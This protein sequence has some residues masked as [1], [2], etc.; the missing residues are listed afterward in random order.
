MEGSMAP[1]NNVSGLSRRK[2]GFDSPWGYHPRLRAS[3]YFPVGSQ[4]S[5]ISFL[6]ENGP[7][8]GSQTVA[9]LNWETNTLGL[10]R[11]SFFYGDILEESFMCKNEKPAPVVQCGVPGNLSGKGE[12]V[13]G[14]TD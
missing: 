4:H 10:L 6:F 14:T 3:L 13:V 5:A 9:I 8:G 2:Q 11:E 12:E 1:I 7:I